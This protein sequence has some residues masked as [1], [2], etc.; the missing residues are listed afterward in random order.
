[1]VTRSTNPLFTGRKDLLYELDG[2]VRD[3][4]KKPPDQ[5]QYRIIISGMGGQRK[6]E[7][8]L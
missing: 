7:V 5:R 4:V 3:A 2:T 6:S 8:C 1:M